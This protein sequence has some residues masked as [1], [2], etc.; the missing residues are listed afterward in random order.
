SL[1]CGRDDRKIGVERE[2]REGRSRK[3]RADRMTG[4]EARPTIRN[5]ATNL[6][7]QSSDLKSKHLN[8]TRL[9]TGGTANF[10]DALLPVKIRLCSNRV[11]SRGCRCGPPRLFLD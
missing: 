9:R 6:R 7:W 5:P 1:R 4:T 3:L 11:N 8:S 10:L 2:G